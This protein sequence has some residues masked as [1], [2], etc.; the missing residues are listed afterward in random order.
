MKKFFLIAGIGALAACQQAPAPEPEATEAAEPAASAVTAW[1]ITFPDGRK[2]LT[3]ATGDGGYVHAAEIT[4]SG[5]MN[6]VEGEEGKICFDPEGDAEPVCATVTEQEDGTYSG[7]ADD[8]S[9]FTST[10][11]G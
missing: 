3:V 5:T 1:E 11:I 8:G 4:Q 7:V 9:T 6:E 10:K 2:G